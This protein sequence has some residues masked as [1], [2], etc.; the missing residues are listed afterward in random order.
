MIVL[1][2]LGRLPKVLVGGSVLLLVLFMLQSIL[3]VMR[4]D[5]PIA[6]LHPVNG[7]VI[8]AIALLVAWSARGY[9]RRAKAEAS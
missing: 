4:E 7:F 5:A 2:V 6:A 3:I 9:L 8:I 1:A